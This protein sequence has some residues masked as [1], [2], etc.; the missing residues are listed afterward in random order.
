VIRNASD[1]A[2]NALLPHDMQA[3]WAVWFYEQYGYWTSVNS[4]I[5]VWA[6][7]AGDQGFQR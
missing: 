6:V 2:I 3:H 4:A 7:I 1:P 5:A